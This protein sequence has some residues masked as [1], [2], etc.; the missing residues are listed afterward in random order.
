MSDQEFKRHFRLSKNS[1]TRL[2]DMLEDDLRFDTNRGM[3]ISP[4]VQIC[5]TLNHYGGGHYQRI[6][7][8]CAG[9]SQNGARRSLQR[10]TEALVRRKGQFVYMPDGDTMQSTAERMQDKFHLPRFAFAVDGCQVKFTSAP[11]KL[12]PNMFAQSFWCRK[13][14]YSINVQLIG[15]DKYIY[16][17]DVGWPGSTHDARVWSRSMVKR[18]LEQQKR[19]LLAGDSGYPISENLVKPYSTQE[20]ANDPRKRLFNRR[21]SG[22]RTMMSECLYGVWKARFP[23]LK[24]LRTD[25]VFSQKIVVATAILFNLARMWDDP[26]PDPEED[27]E[28]ADGAEEDDGDQVVVQD[29]APATIRMRGKTLRDKLKDEMPPN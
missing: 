20:S 4:I 28:D 17:L 22:L 19:F 23:I 14:Y 5:I 15:N 18:H 16:D 2:C 3:P 26:D 6:T 21:L 13:Q 11:R 1:V 27:D 10:V 25:F 7:G 29:A 8:W 9:V 12:P 24:N